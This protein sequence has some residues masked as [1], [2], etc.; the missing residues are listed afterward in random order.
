MLVV[1]RVFLS[2]TYQDLAEVREAARKALDSL[3][4]YVV[5][6]ENFPVSSWSADKFCR[7][8]VQECDI[9]VGVL[10]GCYG[11][12]PPNSE[13]SF[14]EREY[15]TALQLQKPCL[16]FL[17]D[18]SFPI[19]KNLIEEDKVRQKLDDFRRRVRQSHVCAVFSSAES[20]KDAILKAFF[21]LDPSYSG[22]S[23]R[24]VESATIGEASA[25]TH[26][27]KSCDRRKQATQFLDFV[28][29]HLVAH[30]GKPQIYVV[31]GDE[32]ERPRSLV[33]R[34]Y[35]EKIKSWTRPDGDQTAVSRKV[36]IDWPRGYDP[37]EGEQELRLALFEKFDPSFPNTRDIS[38]PAF[39]GLPKLQQYSFIVIQHPIRSQ[40]WQKDTRELA[41]RYLAF[42]DGFRTASS[43]AQFMVF[44]TV[45]YASRA[46]EFSR[47]VDPARVKRQVQ[48]DLRKLIP[49]RPEEIEPA[50]AVGP[51]P[52]LILDEL[53][54]V[55]LDE[56]EDWFTSP[57]FSHLFASMREGIR[58]AEKLFATPAGGFAPC[59][60]MSE[61]EDYFEGMLHQQ[62]NPVR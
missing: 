50:Q 38:A 12:C 7:A 11:S 9:F 45:I 49:A 56:V 26:L 2:S 18:E 28:R 20:L 60:T 59:K 29:R 19:P 27:A 32:S 52:R 58:Q 17:T 53:S 57:T 33:N 24:V 21:G 5:R 61:I 54:C 16:M 44:L 31:H 51:C 48:R 62:F 3:G 22:L 47:P 55:K 6:M 35:H 37:E 46:E 8:R 23:R 4:H 25:G 40:H 36:D 30:P 1:R 41:S 39:Q 14:T 43:M 15:L 42:W 34:L 13:V 10:G